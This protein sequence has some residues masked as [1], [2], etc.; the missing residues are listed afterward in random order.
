[1]L[2]E[3]TLF[4]TLP[5]S[6][7]DTT[8]VQ[9]QS[10]TQNWFSSIVRHARAQPGTKQT[11]SCYRLWTH[12]GATR[13]SILALWSPAARLVGAQ[14]A[15]S[16]GAI[17]GHSSCITLQYLKG[18]FLSK[19]NDRMRLFYARHSLP[20]EVYK[21]HTPSHTSS[22]RNAAATMCCMWQRSRSV[23]EETS[24]GLPYQRCHCHQAPA[25]PNHSRSVTCRN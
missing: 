8:T 19:K 3:I 14:S 13:A 17:F 4:P 10:P 1:M 7:R 20:W 5:C 21:V 25:R 6:P 2:G 15:Y 24:Y 11:A 18:I 22:P 23:F 9:N 12:G 16:E